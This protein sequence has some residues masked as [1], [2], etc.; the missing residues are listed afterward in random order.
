MTCQHKIDQLLPLCDGGITEIT[1]QWQHSGM[2][3][4]LKDKQ[5]GQLVK[6]IASGNL[7]ILFSFLLLC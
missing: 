6:H 7:T 4:L 5:G 2:P 1:M 3:Y